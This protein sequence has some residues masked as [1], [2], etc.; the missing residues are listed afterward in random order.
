MNQTIHPRPWDPPRGDPPG[1]LEETRS[2]RE[3]S[4]VAHPPRRRGA[5]ATW[6][7]EG[8]GAE[9]SGVCGRRGNPKAIYRKQHTLGPGAERGHDHPILQ[10]RPGYPVHRVPGWGL[11]PR[12]PTPAAAPQVTPGI[13]T[14][15][16]PCAPGY[17]P[18]GEP[19]GAQFGDPGFGGT[20]TA[21]QGH[22][23]PTDC[24]M[25]SGIEVPHLHEGP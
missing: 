4:G 17:H 16:L 20:T 8:S 11:P 22:T 24:L 2:V 15:G 19:S 3:V 9:A 21:A 18:G 10:S 5:G 7:S 12:T 6:A 13:R 23:T 25:L 1:T 14:R